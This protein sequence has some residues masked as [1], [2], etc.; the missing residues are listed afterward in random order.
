MTHDAQRTNT[1]VPAHVTEL[2]DAIRAALPEPYEMVLVD[3]VIPLVKVPDGFDSM[4]RFLKDVIPNLP[5][6]GARIFAD[7][8]VLEPPRAKEQPLSWPYT[9]PE[10][11]ERYGL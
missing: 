9:E 7:G 10:I 11:V 2:H 4:R 6:G 5:I 3:G 8:V 1:E